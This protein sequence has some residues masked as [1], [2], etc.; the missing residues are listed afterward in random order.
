MLSI[1]SSPSLVQ[2]VCC[3]AVR[4]KAAVATSAPSGPSVLTLVLLV[5]AFVSLTCLTVGRSTSLL[6]T[7]MLLVLS[8]LIVLC[9]I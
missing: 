7:Q 2:K 4:G 3:L 5:P 6:H 9:V 8:F 1:R